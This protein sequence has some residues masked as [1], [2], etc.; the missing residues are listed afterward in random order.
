MTPVRRHGPSAGFTILEV[1]LVVFLI[2]IMAQIIVPNIMQD[3]PEA[4]VQ[5]EAR[6]IAAKLA[7]LRSEARLQSAEYGLEFDPK[8]NAYRILMPRERLLERDGVLRPLDADNDAEL[9]LGWTGLHDLVT[10]VGVHVGMSDGDTPAARKIY[11]DSQGRTAQKVIWLGHK[12]HKSLIYSILVPPLAGTM[13]VSAGR[14][15][16]KT[17]TDGDF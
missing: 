9:K 12:E 5:S 8:A 11:F 14:Q 7:Y 16:F 4:Q 6:R 10:F 1:L 2:G 15:E 3:L 17:A 13:E